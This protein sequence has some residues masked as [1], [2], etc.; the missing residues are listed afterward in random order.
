MT[1]VRVIVVDPAPDKPNEDLVVYQVPERSRA[2]HLL[3]F[4]CDKA[5]LQHVTIE[6]PISRRRPKIWH[7]IGRH[8][9]W[10]ANTPEALA[11]CS[12]C[13]PVVVREA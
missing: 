2:H 8:K 11:N 1:V 6:P 10:H 3:Q 9:T 5:G 13:T 4:L 12:I 7:Q